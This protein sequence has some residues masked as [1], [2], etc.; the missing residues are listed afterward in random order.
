MKVAGVRRPAD[1]GSLGFVLVVGIIVVVG[2]ALR[3]GDWRAVREAGARLG[4]DAR[5]YLTIARQ[6]KHFYWH[7]YREPL[8][9]ALIR[10]AGW[11][12]GPGEWAPRLV[13]FVFSNVLVAVVALVGWRLYGRWPALAAALVIAISPDYLLRST[14][15]IRPEFYSVLLL[16]F[17]GL[18]A[19]RPGRGRAKPT[20]AVDTGKEQR[21]EVDDRGGSPGRSSALPVVGSPT[22]PVASLP[23][24][25]AGVVGGLLCL[26]RMTSVAFVFPGLV[27]CALARQRDRRSNP[28]PAALVGVVLVVLMVAPYLYVCHRYLG[29]SLI[30]INRH[31]T[32]WHHREQEAKESV[33][34]PEE[35]GAGTGLIRHW[36]ATPAPGARARGSV[37]ISQYLLR[38][39]RATELVSR[40]ARGYATVFYAYSAVFWVLVHPLGLDWLSQLTLVLGW[41]GLVGLARGLISGPRLPVVVALLSLL[42]VCFVVPL[43]ANPR[44]FLHVLPLWVMWCAWGLAWPLELLYSR[45]SGRRERT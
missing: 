13:S 7:S 8:H 42:T 15:G 37:T 18:L 5:E 9:P 12:V 24:I 36:T 32:W 33:E 45:R 17:I 38:E 6:M 1:P 43:G 22:S 14:E 16:M 31:A 27:L 10:M 19:G 11:L 34:R 4:P 44:L 26:T 2:L 40:T 35:V 3:L 30:W 41:L 25:L 39:R 28:W 23:A 20:T 21:P 29:D